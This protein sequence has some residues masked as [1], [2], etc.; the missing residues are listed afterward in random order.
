MVVSGSRVLV[1]MVEILYM[2]GSKVARSFFL[3]LFML[4]GAFQSEAQIVDFDVSHRVI[5]Q[6]ETL[7]FSNQ[8]DPDGVTI[9][10]VE[11][12]FGDT[13]TSTADSPTHVYTA[14]G[15][16]TVSLTAYHASGS[17]L[18]TKTDFIIVLEPGAP[19]II[20]EF[21]AVWL[22]VDG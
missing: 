16:Y 22:G 14:P 15:S 19:V 4:V 9:T 20:N 21:V 13:G 5:R 1:V 7:T 12:D 3:P 18:E 6:D 8:T 2:F 10:S 17:E 11:W